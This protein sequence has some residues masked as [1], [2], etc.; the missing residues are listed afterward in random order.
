MLEA[1]ETVGDL[2]RLTREARGLGIADIARETRIPARYL[3]ALE[4]GQWDILP[5][6]P[7]VYGF[8]RTYARFIGLDPTEIVDKLK[9]EASALSEVQ[10]QFPTEPMNESKQPSLRLVVISLLSCAVLVG[11]WYAYT[12]SQTQT[13]APA[14]PEFANTDS[15]L[16]DNT[17]SDAAN[18]AD[19][20]AQRTAPVLSQSA[21]PPLTQPVEPAP[22]DQ[23]DEAAAGVQPQEDGAEATQA[24]PPAP[25]DAGIV[26]RAREESWV[27]I[28]DANA[29]VIRVGVLAAGETFRLP[30]VAGLRMTTG[31]AGGIEIFVDGKALPALGPKGK[32]ARNIAL[33]RSALTPAQ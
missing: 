8:S 3:T 24:L 30:D 27:R 28:V 15:L 19:L 11:G 23:A 16:Q 26:L 2:L 5:A 32:P 6:K 29:T 33:S 25:T 12:Q 7:Y 4:Q 14:L 13:Q 1:K 31:N 21:A 10:A 9:L 20:S 22:L 18:E 17:P